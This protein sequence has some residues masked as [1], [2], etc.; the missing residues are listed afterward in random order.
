MILYYTGVAQCMH[1]L[2]VLVKALVVVRDQAEIALAYIP[3]EL[4]KG[5]V[6]ALVDLFL[7]GIRAIGLD[8]LTAHLFVK[9]LGWGRL[10]F[11]FVHVSRK[12]AFQWISDG[13]KFR[14]VCKDVVPLLLVD[15]IKDIVTE[16]AKQLNY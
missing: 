12:E 11:E 1:G 9:K 7:R 2:P 16:R 6:T 13:N 10:T 14:V 3:N 15:F 4:R 8:D 5:H